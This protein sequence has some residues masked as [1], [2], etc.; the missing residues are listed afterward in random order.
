MKLTLA[1]NIRSFRKQR[2]LTQER[3]AEVLGVTTGA[4]YKWESGQSVPELE[5]IVEMA[6]F[7]DTSVDV[8]LGYNLKDNGLASTVQRLNECC[9]TR[10][11]EGLTEAEKALKKY[12]NS[13]EVVHNCAQVFMV[14]GVGS[15]DKTETRRA[16]ELLEQARLLIGQNTDPAVS[17]L[18]LLGEIADG[19]TQLGEYEKSVELMKKHNAGGIFSDSIGV[20]LAVLMGRYEE[21]EPFLSYALLRKTAGLL[22]T[23]MGYVFVFCA[24]GDYLSARSILGLGMDLLQGLK[25]KKE[26]A[27]DFTDKLSMMMFAL[28]A[29]IQQKTG[30]KEEARFSMEKAV[31]LAARFDAAP[32]YGVSAFRFGALPEEINAIDGL[33]ATAADSLESILRLLGDPELTALWREV[34][35]R[36]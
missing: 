10:S 27:P 32:N 20:C 31:G 29:H 25:K 21:A 17:E 15:R 18:T 30:L 35:D 34:R 22:N 1:E 19:Y 5:L 12:P 11:P 3:L 26:N 16:L 6:D 2:R 8:L 13:F 33:G 28:Q 9:R 7:F 24:R 23:I 14:Y 4:V 36:G